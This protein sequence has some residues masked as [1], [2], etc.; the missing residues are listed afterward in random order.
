MKTTYMVAGLVLL[1]AAVAVVY[2][3]SQPRGPA[4]SYMTTGNTAGGAQG[5]FAGIWGG[6]GQVGG[7][8]AGATES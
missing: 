3:L 5:T 2:V 6:L 7:A 4:T 1:V 8:I